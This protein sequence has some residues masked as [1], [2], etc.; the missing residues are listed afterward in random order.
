MKVVRWNLGRDKKRLKCVGVVGE[1]AI[2]EIFE[3]INSRKA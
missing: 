2:V 3:Q 1:K